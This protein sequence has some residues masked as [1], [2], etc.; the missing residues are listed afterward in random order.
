MRDA[1]LPYCR[2]TLDQH[3][4]DNV[5]SSLRR[6]WL[7]T[8][9]RVRELEERFA[10]LGGRRH[11]IALN[12]ATAGIHTALVAYGIGPGDEVVLPSLSF[13]AA[14]HCV[15]HCGAVPV[16]CDVEPDT[17]CVSVRTIVAAVTPR[18][19][20][21]V[22]MPYA[23]R[24]VG[25]AGIAAYARARGLRVI[26]DAALGIGTLDEG[27]WPGS[28]ADCAVFSLYATKN[29]TAG[30]GGL[31]VTDD[32]EL[33][34]RIRLLALH[35]MDR[36]AWK[37]YTDGGSWR[38]DVTVTGFKYNLTD[39]AA[40]LCL[41]QL[42]KLD[43]MQA[44]RQAIAERYRSGLAA[45]S[46]V[47]PAALGRMGPRDVHSWC[48][49]PVAVDDGRRDAFIEWLHAARIGT[50]VHYIPSHLFTA[51]AGGAYDL[52]ETEKAWPELV[53]LP[54]YPRMR[55]NDVED[56]LDAVTAFAQHVPERV[57]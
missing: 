26:E 23:G 21:I 32:D 50:S 52:P 29:V 55:D 4:V 15:R 18:T 57:A 10:A 35:G 34:D 54:L 24:P 1:F 44:R 56:V 3:E 45:I 14:A 31:V 17:L 40:S 25:G 48:F 28:D 6:D 43:T 42:D 47:T 19:R 7:T 46:G 36:D 22:T 2:P 27:C 11:A 38:Y 49:F 33:A 5:V 51:Y 8:G 9:P 37:R 20:A 16:F 53:S 41:A 12:S 39:I 30:E 13:V